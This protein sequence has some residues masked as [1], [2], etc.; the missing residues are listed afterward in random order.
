MCQLVF[1]VGCCCSIF[2]VCVYSVIDGVQLCL[3]WYSVL[4]CLVSRL[5]NLVMFQ[6]CDR[7]KFLCVLLCS[8]FV[9]NMVLKCFVFMLLVSVMLCSILVCVVLW[10]WVQK[11][12][13]MVWKMVSMCLLFLVQCL[14]VMMMVWQVGLVLQMKLLWCMVILGDWL[15]GMLLCLVMVCQWWRILLCLFVV[16]GLCW[17]GCRLLVMSVIGIGVLRVLVS[18][19]CRLV[20]CGLKLQ[21]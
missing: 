12:C 10:F 7:W 9:L 13:W 1:G 5:G 15:N 3:I 8:V 6:W 11:V 16:I 21:Y 14:C 2:I 4:F 18:C 17:L 20:N 19:L